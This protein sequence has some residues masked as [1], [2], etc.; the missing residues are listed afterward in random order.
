MMMAEDVQKGAAQPE[1]EKAR[2]APRRVLRNT[3]YAYQER[4]L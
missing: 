2:N 3:L 1:S 4:L